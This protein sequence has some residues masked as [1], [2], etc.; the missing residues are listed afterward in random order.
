[1]ALEDLEDAHRVLELD[2]DLRWLAALEVHP[3]RAVR[4][5][6][7]DVGDLL[8]LAGRQLP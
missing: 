1:V 8:V 5:V 2:V 6:A 3:V 4:L 7:R